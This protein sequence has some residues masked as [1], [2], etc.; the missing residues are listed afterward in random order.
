[1]DAS[2]MSYSS[3]DYKHRI[4]N[5]NVRISGS[6]NRNLYSYPSDNV[7]LASFL[8]SNHLSGGGLLSTPPASLYHSY[9]PLLP[10]P[11]INHQNMILSRRDHSVT[12]KKSKNQKKDLK[13]EE[14]EPKDV[15]KDVVARVSNES[16]NESCDDVVPVD[17]FSGSIVF[18]PS[19]PPSSL[20][21]PTFL[22]RPKVSC[23]AE[24]AARGF[25]AGATDGLQRL[26]RHR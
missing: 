7:L 2:L 20:P 11:L 16:N 17:K 24:V 25:D 10:L 5:P 9:P 23:R 8:A 26:L 12:P 21:L 22:L 14:P 18:T 19:P 1:M 3:G 6:Y 15:A 4:G 13:K